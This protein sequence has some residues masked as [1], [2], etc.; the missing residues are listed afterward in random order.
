MAPTCGI[1]IFDIFWNF[2]IR[3][4]VKIRRKSVFFT[5]NDSVFICFGVY[6]RCVISVRNSMSFDAIEHNTHL[7]K[8]QKIVCGRRQ[9]VNYN[10]QKRPL[11]AFKFWQS[12]RY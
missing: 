12:V 9:K 2:F 10:S 3:N 1:P 11:K 8:R 6:N 5:S 7:P 4:Y